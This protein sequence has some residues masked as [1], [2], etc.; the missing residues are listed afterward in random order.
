VNLYVNLDLRQKIAL[1]YGIGLCLIPRAAPVLEAIRGYDFQVF[2]DPRLPDDTI[3]VLG[4]RGN[5]AF[6]SVGKK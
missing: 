6:F 5:V 3:L 1:L 4:E 2:V